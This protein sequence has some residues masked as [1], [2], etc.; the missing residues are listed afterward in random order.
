[1]IIETSV[2]ALF[3][4]WRLVIYYLRQPL[5]IEIRNIPHLKNQIL[6]KTS[7]YVKLHG[8]R[9]HSK[10]CCYLEEMFPGKA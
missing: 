1:M 9:I 6:E 7:K 2:A 8:I 3:I 4:Y 5:Q 10:K